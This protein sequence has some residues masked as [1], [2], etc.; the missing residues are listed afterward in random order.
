VGFW[1][2]VG[3]RRVR[4]GEDEQEQG[5]GRRGMEDMRSR[6]RIS[7]ELREEERQG[8]DGVCEEIKARAGEVGRGEE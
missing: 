1:G 7:R 4:V 5:A 3:W 8:R 2:E 6:G